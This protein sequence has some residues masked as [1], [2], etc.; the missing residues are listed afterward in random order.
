M[1]LPDVFEPAVT[2][3]LRTR[4]ESLTPGTRALWGKMSVD[5]MLAHCT[6]IYRQTLGEVGG[7]PWLL[8]AFART[9]FKTSIVGDKP[10]ARNLPTPQNFR[11]SD[12]R[13]FARERARLL[14]LVAR[15]HGE[16]APAFEGRAHVT[17]GPL[18]AREWSNLY[19]KHLD[20]HL[21]QFGA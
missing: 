1:P 13:D 9:F 10:F 15:L 4:I 11:V 17:W 16:G 8:R 7:G 19:Y 12:P 20:H 18:S 6:T 3:A 2:A 21:R 5:Q 14:D